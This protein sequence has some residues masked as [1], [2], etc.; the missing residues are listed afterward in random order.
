MRWKALSTRGWP[1]DR[2]PGGKQ[3]DFLLGQNED[4]SRKES[5]AMQLP[6]RQQSPSSWQQ[7]PTPWSHLDKSLSDIRGSIIILQRTWCLVGCG[8]HANGQPADNFPLLPEMP[9]FL[10]A[11]V[12]PLHIA[13]SELVSQEKDQ[14]KWTRP[15]PGSTHVSV[16]AN[17]IT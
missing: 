13:I 11:E 16:R 2:S 1:V 15:E 6:P 5:G 17:T 12:L 3:P 8:R 9:A 7:A 14:S 4:I 10:A